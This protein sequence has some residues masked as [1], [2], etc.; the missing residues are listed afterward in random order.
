MLGL[1]RLGYAVLILSP[2]LPVGACISLLRAA[3]ATTIVYHPRFAQM[4]HDI[5]TDADIM[6]TPLLLLSEYDIPATSSSKRFEL[7]IDKEVASNRVAFIMHSSG[8][9]GLPKLIHQTHRSCLETFA[10]G[11][12]A[13]S[14]TAAPIFHTY[15]HSTLFRSLYTRGTLFMHNANVPV[16]SQSLIT[17]MEKI[18]PEVFLAVPYLLKLISESPRGLKALRACNVVNTSGSACPDEL[19][20]LLTENGVHYVTA[21]GL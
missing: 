18:E 21:L 3:E 15:G 20:N 11:W 9:T 16:T 12:G 17:V 10:F 19:G 4:V 1:S 6:S 2:R 13:R 7:E 5:K 14:F 8:S